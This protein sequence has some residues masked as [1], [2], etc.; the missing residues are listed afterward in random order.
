MAS[1]QKS[2]EDVR[3][4]ELSK[5][6]SVQQIERRFEKSETNKNYEFMRNNCSITELDPDD[7]IP[8]IYNLNEQNH[9]KNDI[10]SQLY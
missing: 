7:E 3:L 2:T 9:K 1:Y 5:Q 8:L 10:T 4:M 6:K